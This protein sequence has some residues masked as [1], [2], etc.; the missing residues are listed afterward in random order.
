VV[1]SENKK[2]PKTY[3]IKKQNR[4]TQNTIGFAS[5]SNKHPTKNQTFETLS[6]YSFLDK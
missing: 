3:G 2:I 4:K 1:L 6:L 5:D